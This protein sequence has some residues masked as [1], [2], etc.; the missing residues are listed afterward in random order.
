MNYL[1]TLALLVTFSTSFTASLSAQEI[2]VVEK[3]GVS[4]IYPKSESASYTISPV[5]P[6]DQEKCREISEKISDLSRMKYC[7]A[8]VED[9]MCPKEAVRNVGRM[10]AFGERFSRTQETDDIE[11]KAQSTWQIEGVGSNGL[12]PSKLGDYAAQLGIDPKK[13]AVAVVPA[14]GIDIA[15]DPYRTQVRFREPSS[16]DHVGYSYSWLFQSNLNMLPERDM[17]VY[18][19]QRQP[20]VPTLEITSYVLNCE[21]SRG[22]SDYIDV[23]ADTTATGIRYHEPEV[24][25]A[26]FKAYQEL[27]AKEIPASMTNEERSLMYGYYLARSFPE[28]LVESIGLSNLATMLF[29]QPEGKVTLKTLA[30]KEQFN[31]AISIVGTHVNRNQ[32]IRLSMTP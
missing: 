10:F 29:D 13:S 2:R 18:I 17:W 15:G 3:D 20:N 31:D 21:L 8:D 5:Q 23:V 6:I 32:T 30:T 26:A 11:V 4:W 27:A 16:A 24:V 28:Q 9:P 1:K 19:Q 12:D 7:R 22:A 14:D 25:D